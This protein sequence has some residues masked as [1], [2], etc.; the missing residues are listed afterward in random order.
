MSA[1]K[2]A[3]VCLMIVFILFANGALQLLPRTSATI[4]VRRDRLTVNVCVR[5]DNSDSRCALLLHVDHGR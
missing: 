3:L 5:A 4:S 2:I 1:Q